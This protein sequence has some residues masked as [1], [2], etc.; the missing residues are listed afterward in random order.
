MYEEGGRRF[1]E[2]I[3]VITFQDGYAKTSFNA[4]K[5]VQSQRR[6]WQLNIREKQAKFSLDR[7]VKVII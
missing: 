1:V 7:T 2:L 4:S 6:D 3:P 5:A